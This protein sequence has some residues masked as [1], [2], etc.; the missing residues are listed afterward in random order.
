[1]DFI[2]DALYWLLGAT[3]AQINLREAANNSL[4]K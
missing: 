4:N 2:Y 3:I 1:M